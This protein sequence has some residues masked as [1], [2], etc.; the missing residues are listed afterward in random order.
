MK[1]KKFS[2]ASDNFR[3]W[4][5]GLNNATENILPQ[6]QNFLDGDNPNPMEAPSRESAAELALRDISET[7]DDVMS[8]FDGMLKSINMGTRYQSYFGS[9]GMESIGA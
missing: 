2:E 9:K 5:D 7:L 6:A 1:H 8:A 3:R 4:L